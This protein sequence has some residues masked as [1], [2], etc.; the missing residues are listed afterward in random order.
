MKKAIS[1]AK[2]FDG[3]SFLENRTLLIEDGTI[4]DIV[5][6]PN[7]DSEWERYYCTEGILAPGFID[8][9]VN[10]GG[11]LLFNNAT[12]SEAIDI[13]T[14]AHHRGG[15]SSLMPT[16]ITDTE[17]QRRTALD[18]VRASIING[19]KSVLGLHLE[20]P[21]FSIEK[22]GVH[23]QEHIVTM[24]DQECAWLCSIADTVMLLTLA[25][26]KTK[27]SQL[28]QLIDAGVIV[29][30]G[31]SNAESEAVSQALLAGVKGF[32]HLFNAMSPATS[33]EPGVVGSA[34][35]NDATWCGIIVDG[36][37]VHPDMVSLAHRIKPRGKLCLVTDAMATVFGD[38]KSFE[39]YGETITEIDGRLVNGDGRLAGACISMIDAVRIAHKS[40]GIE[41]G[42]CLRMASLYSAEYLGLS[43]T[44]GMLSSGHRA[45]LVH[46]TEHFV[47]NQTWVDGEEML[48]A[49]A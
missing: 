33:R 16:L 12:T 4:L 15:T 39:L 30:I 28:R 41:L 13:I 38:Q 46:F 1:A 25:P 42:E 43:G 29:N 23:K 7:L 3:N 17:Q 20:G 11:G 35:L 6:E 34:L 26:E 44:L 45:D 47:V 2:I 19:N 27:V 36:H 18:S 48:S 24:S 37:H 21:F 32:T 40:A 14:S 22:K 5:S 8:W 49:N 10:G 31:H 9:Q